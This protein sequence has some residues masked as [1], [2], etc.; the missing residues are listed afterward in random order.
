[1]TFNHL[2]FQGVEGTCFEWL[3]PQWGR[4]PSLL[5]DDSAHA[6]RVNFPRTFAY[7][8]AYAA[9]RSCLAALADLSDFDESCRYERLLIDLDGV[10]AGDSPATDPMYGTPAELLA[11]L[12]VAVDRMVQL[13]GD[14]LSLELFLAE[15]IDPIT[16]P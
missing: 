2:G 14:A 9:A 8:E 15:V 1:M 12:E 13:G 11:R 6:G 7:V 16:D 5:R 10:H 3:H 4:L